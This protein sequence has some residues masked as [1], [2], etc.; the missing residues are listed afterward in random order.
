LFEQ[1]DYQL[2]QDDSFGN[3]LADYEFTRGNH[4][5]IGD[6]FSVILRSE[7]PIVQSLAGL[8][9]HFCLN[10]FADDRTI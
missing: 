8:A 3:T 10:D 1:Q 5:D 4:S 9:F 6:L 2:V 7:K